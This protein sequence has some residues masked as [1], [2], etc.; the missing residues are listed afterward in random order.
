MCCSQVLAVLFLVAVMTVA[1]AI[2]NR[3]AGTDFALPHPLVVHTIPGWYYL[4]HR[5]GLMNPGSMG[6]VPF[7]PLQLSMPHLRLSM[8]D[9]DFT[10]A[11]YEALSMLDSYTQLHPSQ[12][13]TDEMLASLPCHVVEGSANG[14]AGKGGDGEAIC[15]I[16]LEGY[17]PGN[18]VQRLHCT[19]DFHAG[20]L[21]PWLRQQGLSAT[22]PMCK[23]PVWGSPNA[24][25][26]ASS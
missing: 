22:C 10:D 21:E 7:F 13:V 24:S 8:V 18:R 17:A 15:A 19:H 9:R 3:N 2:S 6:F 5:Q 11:D 25:P 23:H 12:R 20:C 4:H 16:C 14:K 1:K 26:S